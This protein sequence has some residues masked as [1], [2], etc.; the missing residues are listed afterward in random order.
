[1]I[2]SPSPG[3][4]QPIGW[5]DHPNQKED[6]RRSTATVGMREDARPTSS[7]I[8]RA[9]TAI[10]ALAKSVTAYADARSP[11]PVND[12][13]EAPSCPPNDVQMALANLFAADFILTLRFPSSAGEKSAV[14]ANR[15]SEGTPE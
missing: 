4:F 10:A 13:A 5:I 6:S 2:G 15:T 12:R 8:E 3:I 11:S 9:A 7:A 14:H 1:V